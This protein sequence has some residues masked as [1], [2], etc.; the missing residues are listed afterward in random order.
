MNAIMDALAPLGVRDFDMPASSERVWSAIQA[1][2]APL[3][4]RRRFVGQTIDQAALDTLLLK[5]RTQNGWLPTP[6]SDD[7]L[8]RIYE[9]TRMGSTSG[10]CCPCFV[11]LRTPDAKARL[12]P[13]LSPG[14]V[15]KTKQ[16]AGHRDH[17]LRHAASSRWMPKKLLRPPA[18]DGPR[19]SRRNPTLAEL[20]GVPQR[21]AAGRGT[22][23]SPRAPSASTW[24]A[25]RASTTPRSTPSSSPTA[26]SSPTS[27]ANIGHGDPS[28]VLQRL[29][30]LDFEEACELL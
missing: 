16:G 22:S 13:A 14:N 7:Q 23:C 1:A 28:K 6:V 29:P 3:T 25:C 27:S 19:R 21:H 20:G 17:R 11:F 8:R 5:A 15:D 4:P 10:N 12:L 18:R 24:A 2:R 30:R 9:I 26:A